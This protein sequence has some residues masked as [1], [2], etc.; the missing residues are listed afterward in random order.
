MLIE[1]KQ[2]KLLFPSI[3]AHLSRNICYGLCFITAALTIGTLG[4]HGFEKME[5]L[6]AF[7]NASMILSGMGPVSPLVTTG[8]KLFAS[9]FALFSGLLFVAILALIFAPIIHQFFRKI[10]L[11]NTQAINKVMGPS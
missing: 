8:G 3:L 5:W 4:Y 6:D 10:H 7:L 1:G 9:F 2:Y 11:E